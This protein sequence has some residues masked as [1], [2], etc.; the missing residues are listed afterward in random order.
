MAGYT[1][2]DAYDRRKT[3]AAYFVKAMIQKG[4]QKDKALQIAS[5]YYHV[6]EDDVREL[7]DYGDEGDDD[8][9]LFCGSAIPVSASEIY[10]PGDFC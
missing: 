6:K 7:T 1:A 3:K 8:V 9:Y 2:N 4:Q 5:R 10:D